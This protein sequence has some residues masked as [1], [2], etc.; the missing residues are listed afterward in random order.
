M[1]AM[2][3][4]CEDEAKAEAVVVSK[5]NP[6]TYVFAFACFGLY[7]SITSKLHVHAPSDSCFTWYVLNGSIK[8]FTTAQKCANEQAT[9]SMS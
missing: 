8:T 3:A 9:P 4:K 5:K 7:V 6:G 1:I 2:K